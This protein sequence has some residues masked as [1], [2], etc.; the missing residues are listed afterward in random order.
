MNKKK[1]SDAYKTSDIETA[2][3]GKIILMLFDGAVKFIDQAIGGFELREK[4]EF[5]ETINNNISRATAILVELRACL[6][7]KVGGEFSRTMQEL[8]LYM[9]DCLNQ[10]N[11]QKK[12]EPILEAKKHLVEIRNAWHEMLKKPAE[13][14]PEQIQSTSIS[15]NA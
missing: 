14:T 7:H 13:K 3:P 15:C 6:D 11:L 2:P 10:A 9:E 4:K 12:I 8:Y 5:N 1:Y